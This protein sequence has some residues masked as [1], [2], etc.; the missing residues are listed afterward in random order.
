MSQQPFELAQ[1]MDADRGSGSKRFHSPRALIHASK[2]SNL[3]PAAA[4]KQLSSGTARA[5][6]ES[7]PAMKWTPAPLLRE[8]CSSHSCLN[9]LLPW[10]VPGFVLGYHVAPGQAGA[11]PPDK[12]QHEEASL[13]RAAFCTKANSNGLEQ[14]NRRALIIPGCN[15][16]DFSAVAPRFSL[17]C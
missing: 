4:D 1:R 14:G 6:H 11:Q 9:I 2:P 8:H 16:N 7:R 3:E 17:A 5:R 13:R 15:S 10:P 12:K